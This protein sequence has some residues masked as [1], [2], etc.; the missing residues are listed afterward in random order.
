MFLNGD[1]KV[2]ELLVFGH[3]MRS[4]QEKGEFVVGG[5]S[6]EKGFPDPSATIDSDKLRPFGGEIIRK[7]FVF[8]VSANEFLFHI[9]E[10]F[11]AKV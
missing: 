8:S 7:C 6:D 4:C 11:C 10:I 5:F 3:F 1:G 9:S 2:D